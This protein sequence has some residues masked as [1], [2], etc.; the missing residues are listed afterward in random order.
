MFL[1]FVMAFL[2]RTRFSLLNWRREVLLTM[3][4]PEEKA[5]GDAVAAAH[6]IPDT[7]VRFRYM[8]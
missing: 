2:L 8:T 1:A 5:M 6:E 3:L 7:D 4:T